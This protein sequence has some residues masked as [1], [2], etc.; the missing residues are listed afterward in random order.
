[1]ASV[2]RQRSGIASGTVNAVRQAGNTFGIAILGSIITGR[3]IGQLRGALTA[4]DVPPPLAQH[5]ASTTV[6]SDGADPVL[7]TRLMAGELHN[8][9]RSAF[10]SGLHLAVLVA[11]IVTLLSAVLAFTQLRP[12]AATRE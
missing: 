10:D 8:L 12:R 1:M 3:A 9:Y 11:G 7:T 5:V 6:T 2:Q 4:R